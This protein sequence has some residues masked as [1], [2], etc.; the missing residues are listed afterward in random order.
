VIATTDSVT[1]GLG[2]AI[3]PISRANSVPRTASADVDYSA[4]V[5]AAAAYIVYIA[6][7][8]IAAWSLA[9]T[10]TPRVD[11]GAV[12]I[13]C[14]IAVLLL[15]LTSGPPFIDFDKAYLYAGRAALTAPARMYDC[16]RAQCF[17][18]IPIVALLFAPLA[19]MDSATAAVVFS[20]VG[21]A[22]YAAAIHRLAAQSLGANV[23]WLTVVC[24]PLY[25]SLRIGNTSH[26]LLL[27]LL[28]AFDRLAAGRERTAGT[29]LGLA[30]LLKPP[31]ALFLPYLILRGRL[32]A[33]ALMTASLAVAVAVSIASF[34]IELHRFWF[35][36]FVVRHGGGAI[37]AY[38]VQS[39]NGAL[40]HLLLRGQLRDWTPMSLGTGFRVTS[41][42]ISAALV[43][44]AAVACWRAGPPRTA[45]AVRLELWIVLCLCLLVAPVSWSHYYL[46]LLMPASVLLAHRRALAP[47]RRAA[48][49]AAIL[50]ITPPVVVLDLNRIPLIGGIYDRLLISHFFFGGVLLLFVLLAIRSDPFPGANGTQ[51]DI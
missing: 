6:A 15:L 33:A 36:E 12:A 31:L 49:V 25:Y 16:T 43:L 26:M 24:G 4:D 14:A 40:T 47:R 48:L 17:V 27:P 1:V 29:M 8:A 35:R 9:R 23:W 50:L 38:N 19:P 10:T 7:V 32:R 20:I 51:V 2:R 34:G 41:A 13:G 3:T 30:A 21:I 22:V 5:E 45:W 42:A 39:V 28:V 46:L 18:N 11:A 44:A 37:A